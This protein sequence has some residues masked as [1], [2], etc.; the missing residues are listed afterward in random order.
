[1]VVNGGEPLREHIIMTMEEYFAYLRA[2]LAEG[3]ISS[4]AYD[5]DLGYPVFFSQDWYLTF[6]DGPGEHFWISGLQGLEG[7]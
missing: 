2:A 4:A 5:S 6:A 3:R 7:P 1:V